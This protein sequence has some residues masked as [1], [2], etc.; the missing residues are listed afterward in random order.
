MKINLKALLIVLTLLTTLYIL[1][2]QFN[3]NQKNTEIYY[4]KFLNE[5]QKGN[6]SKVQIRGDKLEG[7]F[8]NSQEF[9]VYSPFDESLVAELKANNVAIEVKEFHKKPWY[10]NLFLHWGPLLFLI[11]I[12][13]FI[14]SRGSG[15]G[16]MI[17]SIGKSKAKKVTEST[18]VA[19]KDVAGIEETKEE[20]T[21][22]V[23][24]LKNPERY[25][26]VG[27]K[28]PKGVILV[29]PPGTGKTLLAKAIAGE[30]Q[31]PFF[32]IA[33]SEFVEMFV[34]VGASRVRDLF[35]Q[36][37]MHKP[38]II[39]ID[40]IDAVGRQRGSGLGSGHDERE[41]TLNQLLSELDG[42]EINRGV[43]VIAAT[44]R[45]DILDKAILRPGRFDRHIYIPLPDIVSR[46]A[47]LEV[48]A[49][50][51]KMA[52]NIN[53]K[54]IAKT[55]H[56]FS[57]AQL[58]NLINEAA[59][60][61]IKNNEKEICQ[62]NL[63]F[64]RDKVVLGLE[65]KSMKLTIENK[66]NIAYHEAGHALVSF[67]LKHAHPIHK[68]SIIPTG[69]GLGVTT[70]L[71]DRDYYTYDKE[72]LE[73]N[74][75]IAMGGKASEEVALA[76]ATS[77]AEG[78]LKHATK[79]AYNMVCKW[80]MSFKIGALSVD[81]QN[82]GGFMDYYKSHAVSDK[83]RNEIDSD[84]ASLL[85]N[86]YDKAKKIITKHRKKL[87]TLAKKLLEKEIITGIEFKKIIQSS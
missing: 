27:S 80:G 48:H 16:N 7:F 10:I 19:F 53:L 67:Y 6:I 36:A 58:A 76:E 12:W 9:F 40:E 26:K 47:I 15:G 34:G 42:F 24:F 28:I 29:G 55:T 31:V 70:F 37:K 82:E 51:V 35:Q 4:D 25:A 18:K 56:G 68:I 14:F 17:F 20:V 33:G 32:S 41:Q 62:E 8:I 63:N 1:L 43:I 66:R 71:P 77:N 46:E 57:G 2:G 11:G 60:H 85:K 86:S 44:N 74:I 64:A 5:L 39:F 78:D 13:I 52:K 72:Q 22:I 38:C 87:D 50:K 81:T 30:A 49:K 45:I 3:F 84:V 79:L 69:I 75:I 23:E 54:N 61:S 59:L 65:R 83:L 21:E 73:T